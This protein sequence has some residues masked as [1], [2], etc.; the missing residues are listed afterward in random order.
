M[1]TTW[2]VASV[3]D[4]ATREEALDASFIG[5]KWLVVVDIL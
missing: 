3:C 2:Q 1:V 5:R 4:Y